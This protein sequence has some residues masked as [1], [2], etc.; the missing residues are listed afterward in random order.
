MARISKS[1][2]AK[3]SYDTDRASP[4]TRF[5]ARVFGRRVAAHDGDRRVV[6]YHW[7]GRYYMENP[8]D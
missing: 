2:A 4:V 7:R 5:L 1:N 8:N 3:I 6:M